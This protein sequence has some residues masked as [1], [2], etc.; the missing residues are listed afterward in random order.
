LTLGILY[1]M[2]F[3]QAADGSLWEGEGSFARY[4]DSLAPYFDHVRLAVPTFDTPQAAGSRVRSTN[5]RLSPLPYFPGPRQFYPALPTIYPR[6]REWVDACDV[7]NF[8]VPT[9]AGAFAFRLARQAGK[10]LFLLVVGDYLALLPH[11]PYRGIKR[12][13]FSAYVSFEE[14]ALARMT[15]HALTFA[16]GSALRAKHEAQGAR[17]HETRT[18]T[19]SAEDIASRPDTCLGDEIRL[20]SVS[21]IDPRKGLRALPQVVATLAAEGVNV[22][23]DIVGPTIGQIGDEERDAIEREARTLGVQRRIVLRGAVPLDSLMRL[24][25]DYDLF[26]LPTRPGEGVPRVLMEAMANGLPV[27]TTNVAGIGSL[28]RDDDNGL[29]LDEASPAAIASAIRR[30][31]TTPELR[32]RLIESGYETARAH[33]L[34][35][36]AAEMM[37]VV[38]TELGIQP[39]T[40]LGQPLAN[41]TWRV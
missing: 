12:A 40:I 23:L 22:T 38:T 24:Y 5:V 26:V 1:H 8:R 10:P 25:R 30:L 32:R 33:T 6:L 13:L 7:L 35:R 34:E 2:P 19:L 21:R 20:L 3:W 9:P 41:A 29:L 18:T 15:R 39:R 31:V 28:I 37:R 14:R 11:L 4:V 16:N 36:Q 17:V 27:V